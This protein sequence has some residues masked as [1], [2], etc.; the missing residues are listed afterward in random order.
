MGWCDDCLTDTVCES[1]GKLLVML[2]LIMQYLRAFKRQP[3]P[4]HPRP[5]HSDPAS[6]PCNVWVTAVVGLPPTAC[7]IKTLYELIEGGREC[8]DTNRKKTVLTT[9]KENAYSIMIRTCR[10]FHIWHLLADPHIHKTYVRRHHNSDFSAA[11][12]FFHSSGSYL[13]MSCLTTFT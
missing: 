10:V 12:I 6:W 2:L 1:I 5:N 7:S 11:S 9:F 8:I 4:L 3:P 13:G